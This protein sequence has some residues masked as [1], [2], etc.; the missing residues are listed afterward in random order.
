MILFFGWRRAVLGKNAREI[1]LTQTG[2]NNFVAHIKGP[3]QKAI[4]LMCLY[5]SQ[6]VEINSALWTSEMEQQELPKNCQNL[7]NV[8]WQDKTQQISETCDQ[9]GCSIPPLEK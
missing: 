2:M 3:S 1:N 4:K 8:K 7:T 6:K 5:E 9:N